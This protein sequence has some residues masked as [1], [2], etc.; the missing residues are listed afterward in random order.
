MG[1]ITDEGCHTVALP[2]EPIFTLLARD[3]CGPEV[4]RYWITLRE[5]MIGRGEK[6]EDDHQKLEDAA[7]V[8]QDMVTWRSDA[9]DPTQWEHGPRWRYPRAPEPFLDGYIQR[10]D[11]SDDDEGP[12]FEILHKRID[13][14]AADDKV[15]LMVKTLRRIT[16]DTRKRMNAAKEIISDQDTR[17]ALLLSKVGVQLQQ[18]AT[19]GDF[20]YDAGSDDFASMADKMDSLR[21]RLAVLAT[22]ANG[23]V[24]VVTDEAIDRVRAAPEVDVTKPGSME[25]TVALTLDVL[26]KYRTKAGPFT[27]GDARRVE[28][29]IKTLWAAHQPVNAAPPSIP[30][31]VCWDVGHNNFYGMLTGTGMGVGFH[32]DWIARKDEFPQRIHDEIAMPGTTDHRRAV[33]G[34]PTLKEVMTASPRRWSDLAREADHSAFDQMFGHDPK[35][36]QPGHELEAPYGM[37]QLDDLLM[38]FQRSSVNMAGRV[39]SRNPAYQEAYDQ[40]K[41]ARQ[42]IIDFVHSAQEMTD[43]YRAVAKGLGDTINTDDITATP[44][45]P[46]HRFTL[47]EKTD[48]WAYG[49]GLEINPAHI[50]AMLDRMQDDGWLLHCVLGGVERDK[51]GMIF[52]R[53]AT[54]LGKKGRDDDDGIT[55]GLAV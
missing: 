17:R 3:P 9:T 8:A 1:T 18:L 6:P 43:P 29:V 49:R 14:L 36:M 44:E 39:V 46:P 30:N 5:A 27:A 11:E 48:R 32:K 33:E 7:K 23:G 37:G 51:F 25:Q 47:F 35:W 24:G 26:R 10:V 54:R 2:D 34:L 22:D 41:K 19:T 20:D 45:L 21:N 38:A 16:G 15:T 53:A 31:H 42:A 52:K 28:G 13:L 4:I 12:L 55:T 40:H 50:P